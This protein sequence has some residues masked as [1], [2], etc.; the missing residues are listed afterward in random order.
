MDERPNPVL[1][2]LPFMRMG[3]LF[4]LIA[5][6]LYLNASNF[7][8]TEI[9][10]MIMMFLGATGIEGGAKALKTMLTPKE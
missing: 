6:A 2:W 8:H 3:C 1:Q 4:A 5:M 10:A 7:D 9:A